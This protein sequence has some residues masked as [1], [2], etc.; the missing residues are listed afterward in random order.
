MVAVATA[1]ED[2]AVVEP[3]SE[4]VPVL[5]SV[6]VAVT[7]VVATLAVAVAVADVAVALADADAVFVAEVAEDDDEVPDCVVVEDVDAVVEPVELDEARAAS[8]GPASG[9]LPAAP[10]SPPVPPV[11]A[12][13]G[14][15]EP[16]PLDGPHAAVAS[17]NPANAKVQSHERVSMSVGLLL[18]T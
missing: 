6:L 10:A 18:G 17:V 7:A 9:A 3:V 11:P 4:D 15:D 2:E 8:R 13:P 5:L 14:V 12:V 1:V 16:L